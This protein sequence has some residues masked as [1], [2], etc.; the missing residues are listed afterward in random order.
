MRE[1][2]L[3]K[4]WPR[5][6][7]RDRPTDDGASMNAVHRRRRA[8]M[9]SN[10]IRAWILEGTFDLGSR[11]DQQ[12]LAEQLGVSIIPVRESLRQLEAGEQRG[13][14]AA[15][16]GVR[17]PN[18]SLPQISEINRIRERLEDLALRLASPHLETSHFQKAA[19]LNRRMA[20]MPLEGQTLAWS[21]VNRQFHFMFYTPADS[22]LLL[23]M[24]NT[25]WDR[26]LLYRE[27]NAA[28]AD[29]RVHAVDE[30]NEILRNVMAGDI[31]SAAR[32][33]R[34]HIR[35]LRALH[36][37]VPPSTRQQQAA[38]QL[39]RPIIHEEGGGAGRRAAAN[40]QEMMIGDG[41]HGALVDQIRLL[42]AAAAQ[43]D[44]PRLVDLLLDA[45][46]VA[47]A[48]RTAHA[49]RAARSSARPEL[50]GTPHGSTGCRCTRSTSTTPTSRRSVSPPP[51][52]PAALV[53]GNSASASTARSR[54][55][56][57]PDLAFGLVVSIDHAEPLD[58]GGALRGRRSRRCAAA[59]LPVAD[60]R[61]RGD[62]R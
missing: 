27:V 3:L 45:V 21:E 50:R 25:L 39:H 17:Y 19:D 16:R 44:D 12:V 54:W 41:R 62:D 22:P 61:Q 36:L 4:E 34:K 40:T 49:A 55:C 8:T 37:A 31:P 1:P 5:A 15:Q 48:G 7:R 60:P 24:I 51:R 6:R 57:R 59:S 18:L 58:P 20:M 42:A 26:M 38:A 28:R 53:A 46:G 33:V 43:A 52:L 47:I 14:P 32:S 29:N 2:C 9:W 23:Q 11:L 56:S 13:N 35:R 10:E 30:H